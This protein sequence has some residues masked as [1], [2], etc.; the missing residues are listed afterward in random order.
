MVLKD[1]FW[2][3][4]IE[5]KKAAFS[6]E[7]GL[8]QILTYMLGSP[9]PEQPSYGMITTGGSF[10]FLKLV[11]GEPNRVRSSEFGVRSYRIS[12]NIR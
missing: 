4:A 10:V 6:I 9:Q 3:M 5:S 1:K 11:K 8:A 2:V 12:K 7:A